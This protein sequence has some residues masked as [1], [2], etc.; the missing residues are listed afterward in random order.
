MPFF[1]KPGPPLWLIVGL[2]NPGRQY[3]YNRHN[4]GFLC[5]DVL[6][7]EHKAKADR[8][9]F[10]ALTGMADIAGQRC[11]LM[12][13]NTYMNASGEAVSVCAHFYHIPPE[14]I[15]VISDDVSFPPGMLR[16]RRR[17]SAGGQK[18]LGSIIEHL[19]TEDF[20]RIKLGVGQK[21]HPEY[22]IAD[23]VLS[24]MGMEELK[25]LRAACGDACKAVE[26]IV[27]GEMEEAMGRYSH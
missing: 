12:K 21:P 15:L 25:S 13:P 23:W 7:G 22:D 20:P 10:R 19:G 11:L 27:R 24:N 17:G 8:L 18:G 14:R 5:L 6:A 16:I 2:G 26:L 3:E 4:A 1:K 9:K